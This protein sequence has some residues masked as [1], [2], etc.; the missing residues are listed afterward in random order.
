MTFYLYLLKTG[1]KKGKKNSKI[2]KLL[3]F[4]GHPMFGT[5]AGTSKLRYW[6]LW[7]WIQNSWYSNFLEQLLFFWNNLILWPYRTLFF[8]K[9]LQ[10]IINDIIWDLTNFKIEMLQLWY[11]FTWAILKVWIKIRGVLEP[12]W[13]ELLRTGW[14][15]TS[16]F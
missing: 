2:S 14:L 3:I 1:W 12:A 13:T 15:F 10:K 5:S 16:T 8:P 6:P 9:K 4:L 7:K 11:R